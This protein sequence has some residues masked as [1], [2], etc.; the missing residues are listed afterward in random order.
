[1]TKVCYLG[2]VVLVLEMSR[3]ERD[4]FNGGFRLCRP[5]LHQSIVRWVL[6]ML[7]VATQHRHTV[8]HRSMQMTRVPCHAESRCRVE[9]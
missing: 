6:R 1:M 4:S 8:T 7:C 5:A 2:V 9:W 3:N